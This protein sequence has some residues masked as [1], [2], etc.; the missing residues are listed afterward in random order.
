MKINI[1]DKREENRSHEFYYPDG[2]KN[3]IEFLNENKTP[4]HDD[5][6][7]IKTTDDSDVVVEIALQY[8]LSYSENIFCFA[9]NINTID[10]GTHLSGFKLGLT[11]ALNNYISANNLIKKESVELKGDDFREGITAVISVKVPDPQFEGQTKNKLGNSEVSS[12]VS[13]LVYNK[14]STFLDENP[15]VSKKIIKKC[16]NSAVARE[17]AR[18]AR[19]LARRKN[20]M[21]MGGLPGKL[22]D[23]SE[24]DPEKSEIFIVE[25]DSAGGSAKLARNREFQAILPLKGKILN[26]EKA[27]I[28]KIMSHDEISAMI[29]VFGTGFEG[30]DENNFDISKLRYKKIIIMT[31]ADVDGAHIRT[32]LLTFFYRYLPSLIKNGN[33]YVSQPPLYKIKTGKKEHYIFNDENKDILIQELE[34]SNKKYTLQRFKGLGEMNPEQLSTTTMDPATRKL[35]QVKLDDDVEADRVFTMLMG[36]EVKPRRDFIEENSTNVKNLD[37]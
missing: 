15:E 36:E 31:D 21:Y 27:R 3:F 7:N 2:L 20:A 12:I 1:V 32:L 22:A 23:C 28:D 35:F 37:I 10:G 30:T 26:V 11:R 16:I 34:S 13:N 4:I 5:I 8:N 19:Q 24:E 6:I 25:G 17:A 14:L 9:N 18:K 33:I 29:Q